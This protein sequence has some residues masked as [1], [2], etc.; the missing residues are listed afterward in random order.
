[1]I[2]RSL[3]SIAVTAACAA[4]LFAAPQPKTIITGDK[5][6]IKKS[7]E[8]VVFTGNALVKRGAD[9]LAADQIIQNKKDNTV[10]A[11]GNVDF[12]SVTTDTEPVHF[13][14]GR[15]HYRLQT[16]SGRLWENR[17]LATWM[18]AASTAP[19]TMQADTITFDQSK[20]E[21]TGEGA[22]NIISSSGTISSPL[23]DFYQHDKKLVLTSG[24]FQPEVTYI[25]PASA[26]RYRA[27]RIVM[28]MDEKKAFFTGNVSGRILFKEQPK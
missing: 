23:A 22:V 11:I 8:Q 9:T 25:Q 18:P 3:I 24:A 7:G 19:V 14:A 1:M 17:P 20:G 21:M 6:Q 10:D 5:M 28:L 15:A 26:G 27:D 13:L 12:N 16:K 4:A 2:K